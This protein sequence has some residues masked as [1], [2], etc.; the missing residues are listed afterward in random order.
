MQL[1]PHPD[2]MHLQSAV[3]WLEL[4]NPCEADRELERI[5]P[6]FGAH[7]DVLEIRWHLRAHAKD[8]KACAELAE[9][10][11]T[12][13]PERPDAWIHR[14]F[15]LHELRRTQE[16]LD[17]LAPVADRFPGVW[18]IPYNL[19]CYCAQLGRMADSEAWYRKAL[20]MDAKMVRREARHD[21]DLTPLWESLGGPL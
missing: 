7:P 18:T 19:A 14:S 16:A 5:A 17:A 6:Q 21:P 1:L 13:A 10:L 9:A 20:A 8:W 15:A 11:I 4:G 2:S 12:A 3:G